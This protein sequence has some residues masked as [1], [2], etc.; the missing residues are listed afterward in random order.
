MKVAW[1]LFAVCLTL[2]GLTSASVAGATPRSS[3]SHQAQRLL[4]QAVTGVGGARALD[5]LSRLTIAAQGTRWV[6][7]EGFDPGFDRIGSFEVQISYDIAADALR[8][9]Y[10]AE[11]RGVKRPVHEVI[12]GQ[13]GFIEGVDSNGGQPGLKNMSSER[14]A[15]IRKH[16]RLLNPHLIL[17]DL[18]ANPSLAS[19]GGPV[20]LDGSAHHMLVVQDRVAPMTL[21][22]NDRTGQIAKLTTME[23]DI[24]RRD[25]A[26]E[27]MYS[28]WQAAQQPG[29]RFPSEVKVMFGGALVHQEMRT[30]I[31]VNPS[32][33][34]ALFSFPAGVAP[35]YDQALAAR[36][37]A[38][39]QYQQNHAALGFPRDAPQ[40][41]VR[42]TELA[43]G[44]FL[45][46][47]SSHNSL[48]VVQSQGVTVVEAPFNEI[49]SQAVIDWIKT[50]IPNKFI[51]YAVSTHHHADHSAGL[52]TYA[53]H[54]A[55]IV[56]GESAKPFFE[57]IFKANS[58][59]VRD[60]LAN[61]PVAVP[62]Y[63]VPVN[64]SFTIKDETQPV[65][66]YSM[67]DAHA[68]DMVIA[69][70][71]KAGVVFVSD[72]YSPNPNATTNPGAG[73]RAVKDKI[74][75]LGLDAKMIVGGHGGSISYSALV[76]LLEL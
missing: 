1:K 17:R 50:N 5:Q 36:G 69:Y 25:V 49:R 48:V 28:N 56:M 19:D 38:F 64:G 57:G 61:N 70:V 23:S 40:T 33:D 76:K 6:P 31:N 58:T 39:H 29:L 30:A 66:V 60:A 41:N 24:L 37:E 47:G 18:L 4:Q 68:R 21:Y 54:G 44:V 32:I 26:L 46:A 42:A 14:W 62:I 72:L 16:Q 2:L 34:A 71:P 22:V 63:P 13:F 51:A 3:Q 43:P 65:E 75:V 9:D 59:I 27:V 15:S 55:N 73:A 67:F 20:Q 52:R 74:T 10:T 11:S 35:V 12:A 8:L 53:A 45:L 7:D